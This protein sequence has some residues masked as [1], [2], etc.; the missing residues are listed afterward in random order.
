MFELHGSN[1]RPLL[2]L[3]GLILFL[4]LEVLTPYRKNSVSKTYRW[5]NNVSLTLFNGLL[6]QAAF[7]SAIISTVVFVQDQG[8]GILNMFEAP[9][10]VKLLVT[11]LF[12]D[13]M[14]YV[15]H[16]LNH[17]VPFLWRFHRVHHSDLNMDVSTATRFHF[18]ELAISAVIRICL[19]LFMGAGYLGVVIF[20]S[21]VLFM[22]Q[23]HHS[24]LRIAKWFERVWWILFVPPSMHRIHHSVVIKERDSNYGAI[25]SIWD[26]A[27][28]TLITRLDQERIRIGVGAYNKPEKLNFFRLLAMPFTRPV[29]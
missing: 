26:R 17:K 27:L 18:G 19:I 3:A 22:T 16:L 10:L 8:T 15:W 28:G 20:E 6:I 5:V 9:A 25:F 21:I 14:L 11:V 29:R 4:A 7:S 1:I 12:L 23:F 13:F 24:S 2:F